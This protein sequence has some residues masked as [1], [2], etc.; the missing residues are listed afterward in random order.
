MAS[1][2]T[3][4][5]ENVWKTWMLTALFFVAVI[6]PVSAFAHDIPGAVKEYVYDGIS[7]TIEV[8]K[9]STFNVAERQTYDFNGHFHKGWRSIFLKDIGSITDVVVK[10]EAGVPLKYSSQTLDKHDPAS[11]GKYTR[12]RENGAENIEWYYSAVNEKRTWTI[13]YK[14]HGG[15]SFLKDHDEIYWNLFTDYDVPV[16]RAEA[17]VILPEP[18]SSIDKLQSTLYA[19][20]EPASYTLYDVTAPDTRTFHFAL[21]PVEAK[22]P[23]TIAAGWPKGIVSESA[24]WR[25]FFKVHWAGLLAALISLLSLLV[26]VGYWYATEVR[27]KGRGTIIPEYAPPQSLPPAMAEVLVKE[28][29]TSKAWP[30]TI[31]DLAV[32]GFIEITEE[33]AGTLHTVGKFFSVVVLPALILFLVLTGQVGEKYS[34]LLVFVAVLIVSA[35]WLSGKSGMRNFFSPKEYVLTATKSDYA[36]DPMLQ[37]YEKTFLYAILGSTGRFSTKAMKKDVSKSRALFSKMKKLK[38]DLYKELEQDTGAYETLISRESKR[39]YVFLLLYLL[40]FFGMFWGGPTLGP[41]FGIEPLVLLAAIIVSGTGLYAFIKYE[42]RLSKEG[43]ILR[44]EWLGFKLYLETAERDRLQNLTPELFEKYLPY[45]IIFGVEK[46][47]AKAFDSLN[48][49]PPNWY[50]GGMGGVGHSSTGVGGGGFTPSAFSAS[51]ASSLGSAFGSAG[52]GGA[53]GG[54]GGAGGG[55]GGGGGGAS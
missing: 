5:S 3:P 7:V 49:P 52:G 47:W 27:G 26:G 41:R 16:R 51:F 19:Y 8:N 13:S 10:D 12:Y 39:I 36:S 32:R 38:E 2:Y 35:R 4:Q 17:T 9:D 6:F 33:S 22:E 11:W 28:K 21:D 29:L 46:K 18:A 50:H 55:G 45:A 14:V 42:A 20:R 53:S 23:V 15:I 31:V 54:G 24:Y 44:E 37:D 48:L 40:I 25:D 30:A 34:L 43:A 1:L